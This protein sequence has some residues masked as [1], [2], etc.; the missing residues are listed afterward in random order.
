MLE[1]GKKAPAI[2]L[3][4]AEGKRRSL[5]EFSG[6][7]V[8]LYFYPKDNTSGCTAEACDFRDALPNFSK[9]EAVVIGVS[10][11]SV[12]SHKKFA[13]KYELPFILLSDE[14]KT[15]LEKYGVWQEKSMYGKKYMGVVRTTVLVDEKG[16]VRKIYPKVKVTGHVDEVLKDMKEI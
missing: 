13:A 4:D 3:L 6:K 2:N 12:E 7:K 10:P 14:S 9:A 16:I 15:I 1:V 8:I 11:D 5:K